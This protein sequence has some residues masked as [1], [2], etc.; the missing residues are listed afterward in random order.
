MAAQTG[1]ILNAA[2]KQTR[3]FSA[4]CFP[5][6][7]MLLAIN[8]THIDYF[9]LDVEFQDLNVLKTLPFDKVDISV[10]TVEYNDDKEEIVTFMEARG[11]HKFT[12]MFSKDHAKLQF[13]RD[14][15]FVKNA[16]HI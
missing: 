2:P 12:D 16:S 10:L 6:Y 8:H 11:Y 3:T 13:T 9:S 5:L 7:S 15:V 1:K 14:L 4:M